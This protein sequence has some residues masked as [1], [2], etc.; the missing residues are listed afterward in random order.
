MPR[1]L[2]AL[3][4]FVFAAVAVWTASQP[5]SAGG[6]VYGDASCDGTVNSID[7]AVVLQYSAG[8]LP[9]LGCAENADVNVDGQANSLDAALILQFGAGLISNLGP[10]PTP[11]PTTIPGQECP[12][13]YYWNPA[14][15]H[16][17]SRECPPGLVFD[18]ETLYCVLPLTP[19]SPTATNT[20][21]P[22]SG[23]IPVERPEIYYNPAFW[24]HDTDIQL[25][26]GTRIGVAAN[27]RVIYDN[28]HLDGVSPDGD[29]LP[30]GWGNCPDHSLVGW[31]GDARPGR[32]ADPATL[33]NVICLGAE[34][35][36]T[37]STSGHLYISVNDRGGFDNNVGQW[38]VTVTVWKGAI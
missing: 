37:V 14:K 32:N 6:P 23:T 16:C 21:S 24:W 8:L 9:S 18:P 29:G 1:A 28:H 4:I 27:G 10:A 30:T 38:Y 17:D 3:S 2:F 36:G 25:N 7:A 22:P 33:S 13:G 11:T 19:L 31:V 34:F 12:K 15:G 20:P 26:A 35:D 5:T